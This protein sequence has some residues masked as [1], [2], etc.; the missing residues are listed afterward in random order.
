MR[1]KILGELYAGK[2]HHL[3]MATNTTVRCEP[4]ALE[5][6][7]L[8]TLARLTCFHFSTPHLAFEQCLSKCSATRLGPCKPAWSLH[9]GSK[10]H[11]ANFAGSLVVWRGADELQTESLMKI[12][13]LVSTLFTNSYHR[14]SPRPKL[15]DANGLQL[16]AVWRPSWPHIAFENTL[17][18]AFRS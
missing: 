14:H 15:C 6:A 4:C 7:T 9:L 11:V 1:W 5:T 12:R 17:A 16:R 3:Q 13:G 10:T 2:G 8:A 18:R